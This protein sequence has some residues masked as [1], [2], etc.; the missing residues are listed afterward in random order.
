MTTAP[1]RLFLVDGSALA[2]RAHFAFVKN[3]LR[4]AAGLVTSAP[5]GFTRDLL[6]LLDDEQPDRVAVVFDVSK[7]TF[8]HERFADYKATRERMPDD[9]VDAL[10]YVRRI[11][12][13]LGVPRLGVEGVEAD[14]VVATLA[15]RGA[16]EGYRVFLV[17]GDK[18]FCQLVD[19]RIVIY[20]PWR[21]TSARDG[22]PE[23]LDAAGVLARHGVPPARF[24]DYLAL[25][26]DS[27]DN[28][29]G[30]PGV[31][32]KRAVELLEQL[33]DLEQVLA[34][35]S[36]VSRP[37]TRAALEANR[38]QALLSREL[39]TLVTDV[40]LE[41]GPGDLVRREP[42]R[43]AL[44]A[45]FAELEFRELL[46][47]FST[48]QTCDPH[49]HH[50][51]RAAD[52]PALVRRLRAAP[53]VVFDLETTSLDPLEA[54]IV[55]MAFSCQE[56]E[57]WYLGAHEQAGA[58]DVA[59]GQTFD[60][61]PL[62]LDFGRHLDVLRPLLEDPAVAKGG[63]NVKYDALVLERHGVRV[64]G[65]AFDTLLESYLLDPS[66]KTHNLD[67]LALRTLGYKKIA[68]S[69]LIGRGRSKRTMKDA[70]DREIFPYA[71]ED[72]DITFRLHRRF[73]PKLEA[74]PDLLRLYREVELP[75][76]RVLMGMERTG[77]RVDPDV[78]RAIGEDLRG[79]LAQQEREIRAIA[80]EGFNMSS[81]KQVGALLFEKLA[82]HEA[83]GLKVKRTPTGAWSTDHEVLEAL[84]PHHP[85]PRL[86]LE[87]R[88]LEK[89]VGTYVDALLG[90]IRPATGRVHTSFNQAVTA[91]GRLSSSDPNLQNIPIRTPEGRLIR[92]AFV[93][94]EPG[95]S[96]LSADYSQVELRILA[97]LSG[98]ETLVAAFREGLDVHRATAARI[99]DVPLA[100]VTSELRGRAKA[101]NFGIVYGMGAQR[102]ARETGLS[103]ADARAFID[104][105]F[106][107]YPR[108]QAYL[109]AQV[110]HAREHGDVATALGRR[111]PLPEIHA[112]QRAVRANAER[113]A[114]NTPI[115]GTAADVIKVAM[116]RID[117]RL[118]RERLRA[119][120]LLQV[121]DELLF[122]A[123]DD[124]LDRLEALVREEM[125][126]AFPLSVP[127]Q[128]DIGRG[129]SW[130]EAH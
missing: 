128:V 11:V 47:R 99:F 100:D 109:Q 114:V 119:R 16:A 34:R 4:N 95:W 88:A 59:P 90:L 9:L 72:A 87:H 93:A 45:L 125:S 67:D 54:E 70:P 86:I 107:K 51:V 78:L 76:V 108:I 36:E 94:G 91:T 60:L 79:K 96:L 39:V 126:Q 44:A 24:R 25:V 6:R 82:V 40:P 74:D 75:L 14:D 69:E 7:R 21:Q 61:F 101:I 32:P 113:M 118:A 106:A 73:L 49:V 97:H 48:D 105:Y 66:Q 41:V 98:D 104:A 89:L 17:T 103:L 20:D 57:A 121:H 111:R 64:Q 18:D 55:G 52:L 13:A 38:E 29:P 62:E 31:G 27:S 43:P 50:R 127:L 28:V 1:P 77:V 22:K 80:G 56:G 112:T 81:P 26:G 130:L 8:R 33:G 68:T 35:T 58:Q 19:D 85:L 63:Q 71:S 120:M 23:V 124:E 123:P 5:Y 65:I 12:D 84:A 37:S 2:Y 3:P 116:V 30:V 83:A 115:Q 42:D 102:L 92:S 10:P 53:E 110:E 117:R 129:R 46:R 122:E 15:R